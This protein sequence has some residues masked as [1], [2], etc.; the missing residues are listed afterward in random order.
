MGIVTAK[1]KNWTQ[2]NH[3]NTLQQTEMQAFANLCDRCD[4]KKH[5]TLGYTRACARERNSSFHKKRH[6]LFHL[7]SGGTTLPHLKKYE[8]RCSAVL[9]L[10][11]H[12]SCNSLGTCCSA[13]AKQ[14]TSLLR[15]GLFLEIS[16]MFSM[17]SP[18]FFE[19][20]PLLSM[21]SP[22]FRE[23]ET[24]VLL[25]LLQRATRK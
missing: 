16:P 22:L 18:L 3:Q 17:K 9:C 1:S 14:A 19:K 20:S 23:K 12:T 7:K 5:K 11:L 24:A 21:K 13:T 15:S 4:S 2:K 6:V 25:G 10:T 8:E